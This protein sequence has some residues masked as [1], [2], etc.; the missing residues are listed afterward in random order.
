MFPEKGFE[1][2]PRTP[3]VSA[4]NLPDCVGFSVHSEL[5]EV[6]GGNSAASGAESARE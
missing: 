4:E 6:N 5:G 2:A 1:I 3:Q